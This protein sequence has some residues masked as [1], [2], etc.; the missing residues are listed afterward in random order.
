MC[1]SDLEAIKSKIP[2]CGITTDL[3]VGFPYEEEQDFEDTLDIVRRVKYSSAF[4]FI[5]SIRK[6]T[7]AAQMPQISPQVSKERITRLIAEQNKVT[8]ELSKGYEGKSY[9][10]LCEDN[11][12]KKDGYVCGRTDSGR[13]VTFKGDKSLI[14]SF[15]N[16]TIEKSQSASL[17]G[18]ITEEE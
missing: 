3:M 13:M 11:A 8:K 18:K 2:D 17:F 5:Y 9:E 10:I 12:P 4:T 7:K 1:S 6:G 16:V 14:G 15:V